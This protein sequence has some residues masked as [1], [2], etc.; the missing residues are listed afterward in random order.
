MAT[1]SLSVP[2]KMQ[3]RYDEITALTD[4]FCAERLNEEYAQVCREMTAT[5]CRKRPSPLESGR[6]QNWAAGIVHAV[7]T[8]N[9]GI[10]KTLTPHIRVP[11]ISEWFS[12]G[13]SSPASKSKDILSLACHRPNFNLLAGN[14]YRIDGQARLVS[15]AG[16]VQAAATA[17]VEQLAVPRTAQRRSFQLAGGER[18]L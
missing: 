1:K 6:V 4:A 14:P 16:R 11:E 10:D 17:H 7:C 8:V 3:A 18:Q 12:V 9:F 2:K 15:A 13:K 5:L